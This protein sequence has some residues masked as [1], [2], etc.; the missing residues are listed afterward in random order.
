MS[1]KRIVGIRYQTTIIDCYVLIQRSSAYTFM[2][3]FNH[4]RMKVKF[5]FLTQYTNTK[6]IKVQIH[7]PNGGCFGNCSFLYQ[8]FI[9]INIEQ[10]I[11][12][13]VLNRYVFLFSSCPLDGRP[14]FGSPQYAIGMM[15]F[16]LFGSRWV[17]ICVT[18]NERTVTFSNGKDHRCILCTFRRQRCN[19]LHFFFMWSKNCD[20]RERC[21]F[22]NDQTTPWRT[23]I[24]I[25]IKH[26][27]GCYL[28]G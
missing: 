8:K 6:I 18:I 20:R 25:V 27:N 4:T 5:C 28:K 15:I 16:L 14:M 3:Y 12:N 11:Q 7:L 2:I 13:L 9:E 21:I 19:V 26:T 22:S 24:N 1:C 17:N 23:D 10:I